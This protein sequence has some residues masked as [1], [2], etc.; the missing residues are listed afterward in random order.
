MRAKVAVV[1]IV[2]FGMF[3]AAVVT[4]SATDPAPMA[5]DAVVLTDSA[6]T[7]APL[8]PMKRDNG[9]HEEQDAGECI[10]KKAFVGPVCID[11]DVI[12]LELEELIST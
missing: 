2:I 12:T 9:D 5:T 1:A 3:G 8:T 11:A 4:A 6:D 10:A 7:A